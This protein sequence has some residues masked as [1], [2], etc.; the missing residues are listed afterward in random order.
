MGEPLRVGFC[1]S[2]QGRLFRAAAL[3]RENLGI[4]PELVIADRNASPAL[5]GFCRDHA[6]RLVR[7]PQLPKEEFN[8]EIAR[9]LLSAPLDLLCLTFDRLIPP[10]VVRHFHDR[11]IN[12]HLALLPAFKGMRGF[13]QALAAGARFVGAT[14]HVV[15]EGMDTGSIIAQCVSGLRVTDTPK[16]IG[17]RLFGSM[18][19]MYLQV[20][21]WYAQGR[22]FRDETG[23]VWVR[24]A[25]YGELPISPA[26]EQGFPD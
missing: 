18:R 13:E 14:V 1:V 3:Q 19:L 6:V 9:W 8:A 7:L 4:I 20:I 10:P 25:V 5:E 11:I 24:D 23:R 2:G 21:A 12:L 16:T 15:D 26:V 17:A 22:V